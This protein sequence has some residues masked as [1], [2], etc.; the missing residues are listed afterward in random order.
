MLKLKLNFCGPC[1]GAGFLVRQICADWLDM[2]LEMKLSWSR[3]AMQ[4]QFGGSH[5]CDS[6]SAFCPAADAKLGKDYML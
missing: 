2:D 3:N 6:R 1:L 5:L 4:V